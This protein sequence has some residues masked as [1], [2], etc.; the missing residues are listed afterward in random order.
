MA[1]KKPIKPTER[2]STRRAQSPPKAARKAPAAAPAPGKAAATNAQAPSPKTPSP[3]LPTR[4]REEVPTRGREETLSPT[5][6]TRGREETPSPT[7]PTRGREE[8]GLPASLLARLRQ[9]QSFAG[10]GRNDICPCGSGKRY[11]NCHGR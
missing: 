6:P 8:H 2:G 9:Q 3:S 1:A 11:K 5:L 4:G 10:V 7:L